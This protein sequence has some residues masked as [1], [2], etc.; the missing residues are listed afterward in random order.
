MMRKIN[1][2][3]AA[4]VAGILFTFV[5]CGGPAEVEKVEITSTVRQVF[6]GEKITLTASVSPD[7]AGDKTV[8]WS[9]SDAAIATV[10]E[11]GEVT[12]VAAGSVKITAKAGEKSASVDITVNPA[13]DHVLT[14]ITVPDAGSKNVGSK[15]TATVK[16][17]NFKA[18]GVTENDFAVSCYYAKAGD[19]DSAVEGS[20]ITIVDDET[21]NV[22]LTIP[23]VSDFMTWQIFSVEFSWGSKN[24]TYGWTVKHT[25]NR[26]VGDV[27]LKNG[28]YVDVTRVSETTFDETDTV[29]I[30][31]VAGFTDTGLV[32]GMGVKKGSGT[33]LYWQTSSAAFKIP[34]TAQTCPIIPLYTE[35]SD[36]YTITEDNGGI[37]NWQYICSIDTA[38][39]TTKLSNY[40][41][42]EF[43][44]NY[45]TETLGLDASKIGN[46]ASGWYVPSIK[47][48][49]ELIYKNQDTISTSVKAAY[50]GTDAVDFGLAY[51]SSSVDFVDCF[52]RL[53]LSL[54]EIQSKSPQTAL[55]VL[56]LRVF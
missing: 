36:V 34:L 14:S 4:L 9:T 24:V 42:F 49:Y 16:G 41:I 35:N 5:G 51:W 21:I 23:S 1:G 38:A 47:E 48:L 53:A 56:V 3:A 50:T 19:T 25:A 39:S 26:N 30:A 52:K 12:G 22:T 8:K 17:K 32:I 33:T 46:F 29:P 31:V 55:P 10:D 28:T 43:A 27:I 18:A 37:S 54:G 40:P 20:K 11:N 45:G 44:Q 6:V 7:D 2:L 15:V 13:V